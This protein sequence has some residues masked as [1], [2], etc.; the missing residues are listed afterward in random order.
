[1]YVF[2][3]YP[4]ICCLDAGDSFTNPHD[5]DKAPQDV[6]AV[7]IRIETWVSI[8]KQST[9]Y[10]RSGLTATPLSARTSMD[11]NTLTWRIKGSSWSFSRHSTKMSRFSQMKFSPADI[12]SNKKEIAEGSDQRAS[13]D[14]YRFQEKYFFFR[15]NETTIDA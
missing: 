7:V 2:F 5:D 11:A 12:H 14:L 3:L 6:P 10:I 15:L 13:Y 8:N 4:I 1:M 9:L